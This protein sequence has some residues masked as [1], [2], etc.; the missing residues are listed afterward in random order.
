[1][2]LPAMDLDIEGGTAMDMSLLAMDLLTSPAILASMSSSPAYVFSQRIDSAVCTTF[3]VCGL[4]RACDMR[5][6]GRGLED[7]R[8]DVG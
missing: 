6:I 8:E 2:S 4:C 3:L 5:E 7:P 1:M